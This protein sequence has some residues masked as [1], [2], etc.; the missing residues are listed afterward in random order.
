MSGALGSVYNNTRFAL[1]SHAKAMAALQEQ[2]STGSRINRPSDDSSAAYKI[3]GLNS[4]K[5]SLANYMST[6]DEVSSILETA[7]TIIQDMFS[8][9]SQVKVNLNQII[10]GTYDE[11]GRQR[12][13]DQV[14][15]TLE[16]MISLANTQH[17]S[18]Y[19]FGGSNTNTA[20]YAAQRTNGKITSITY[21]GSSQ[22]QNVEIAP[23][24]QASAYY[25]GKDIFG[26][27]NRA[28]P[29][30]L[31]DTGAA[32]GSGTSSVKG[33][34]WLTV[35]FDGTDYN[36]SIDGGTTVIDV[37]DAADPTNVAVTNANGEVLYVNAAGITAIGVNMVNV[38]GTCDIFNTLITVRDLLE[39]KYEL[40]DSQLAQFRNSLSGSLDEITNLLVGKQTSIGSKIGFIEDLKN[41]LE[42]IKY[43]A[44]DEASML[45]EADIAQLS[46]DITR[47]ETL[48][49]MSLIVAAKLLSVS[50]L[51]FID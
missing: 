18:R 26:S 39:N 13:A 6:I 50:L 34:V 7:A 37:G 24:V 17:L 21:Q 12:L 20:P 51:D 44:E 42:N 43:T 33:N 23:N 47:R 19:I 14:N 48:Y 40:S 32:G 41:S 29:Q 27:N 5:R 8:S 45:Q 25:A 10:S 16:Q 3:L 22:Q 36:L 15:D 46:I 28:A 30:F 49:Q 31:G 2:V 38:P 35:T 1:Q 4:Q 11:A 9:V